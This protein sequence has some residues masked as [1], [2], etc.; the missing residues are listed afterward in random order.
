M[1]TGRRMR[2]GRM[3]FNLYV[4]LYLFMG[5]KRRGGGCCGVI[6]SGRSSFSHES[7]RKATGEGE[8][9]RI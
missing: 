8:R 4:N 1:K 7:E 3:Y 2:V 6:T 5:R 9:Y